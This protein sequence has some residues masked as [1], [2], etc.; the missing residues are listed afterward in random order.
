MKKLRWRYPIGEL[1]DNYFVK[2]TLNQTE[3]EWIGANHALSAAVR[4]FLIW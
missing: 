4:A 2:A 3:Y 1:L